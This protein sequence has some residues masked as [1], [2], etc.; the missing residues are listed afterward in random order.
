MVQGLGLLRSRDVKGLGFEACFRRE[1]GSLGFG[2]SGL[3]GLCFGDESSPS[4]LGLLRGWAGSR[5]M[6]T[7]LP[8]LT[9]PWR[10]TMSH[11]MWHCL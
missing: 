1:V 9:T 11:V 5:G 7:G 2:V 6:Y 4:M 8:Q 3:G 10:M